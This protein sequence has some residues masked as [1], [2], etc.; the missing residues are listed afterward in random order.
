VVNILYHE[1]ALESS[2]VVTGN[3]IGRGSAVSLEP[4]LYTLPDPVTGLPAGTRKI[5]SA[6]GGTRR[7][8][9]SYRNSSSLGGAVNSTSM[10]CVR[11]GW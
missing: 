5:E 9:P 10:W 8:T 3:R 11:A 6:A 2:T 7:V 4:D 1:D